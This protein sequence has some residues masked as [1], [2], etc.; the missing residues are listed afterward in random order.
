LVH[1]EAG[2]AWAQVEIG[3][4]LVAQDSKASTYWFTKAVEQG[5]CD[6]MAELASMW[7][8]KVGVPKARNKAWNWAVKAGR[9]GNAPAQ[10][11]CGIMAAER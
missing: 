10:E 9:Q 5:S 4:Q 1:A 3:K 2:K 6:A 7:F 8:D 11:L